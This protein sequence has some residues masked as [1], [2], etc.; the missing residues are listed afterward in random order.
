[1][2]TIE[3]D[4]NISTTAAATNSLLAFLGLFPKIDTVNWTAWFTSFLRLLSSKPLFS[5]SSFR[6]LPQPWSSKYCSKLWR[7]KTK[8]I[9]IS[10]MWKY[11]ESH[12]LPLLSHTPDFVGRYLIQHGHK[13]RHF[14]CNYGPQYKILP[15]ESVYNDCRI[16]W[17][18]VF[19]NKHLHS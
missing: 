15:V 10:N 1:M 18:F 12:N 11:T 14:V 19:W 16:K 9:I 5:R 2:V 6:R 7:I 4:G 13:M 3:S 8:I 17:T